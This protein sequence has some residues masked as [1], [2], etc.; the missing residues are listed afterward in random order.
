MV[1]EFLSLLP[2]NHIDHK[3]IAHLNEQSL[4]VFSDFLSVLPC[5]HIDYKGTAHLHEQSLYEF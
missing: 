2:C 1:G 3:G 4:Y 5:N